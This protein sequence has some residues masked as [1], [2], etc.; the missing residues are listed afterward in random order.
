MLKHQGEVSKYLRKGHDTNHC[1]RKGGPTHALTCITSPPSLVSV[2]QRGEWSM[3]AVKKNWR[4]A[5]HFFMKAVF[6]HRMIG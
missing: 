3:G 6:R 1:I 5:S 2:A 4:K